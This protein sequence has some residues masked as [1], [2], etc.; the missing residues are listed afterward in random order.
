M[1]VNEISDDE[2][3]LVLQ[4]DHS[5]VAGQLAAAWGNEGFDPLS[6]YES[7]V[8]AAHEH[9]AGWW[10]WEAKPTL[11]AKNQPLDYIGSALYLG[12]VWLDFYRDVVDRVVREDP[13]AGYMVS[14]HGDGLLTA[15][16]GIVPSLPDLS[17][18]SEIA[19]FVQEQKD[20]RTGLLPKLR[21]DKELAPYA[22]DDHIWTNYRMMEVFDQ[23]AQF[24]CNRYPFNGTR[25][26]NGP[27]NTLSGLAIP[28]RAGEPDTTLSIDVIDEQNAIVTPYPFAFDPVVI[29][30]TARVLPKKVYPDRSA[31]L[32]DFYTARPVVVTHNLR[33]GGNA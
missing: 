30:F 11:N 14:M 19:A 22:T 27:S 5:R 15:G 13:Y 4:V 21:A 6:P 31:F 17:S 20:Y 8:L 3:L 33:A 18:R 12:D 28:T 9:D 16:M 24:I 7:M 10:Q 32:R 2:V 25:R 29:S 26:T 1:M 23:L